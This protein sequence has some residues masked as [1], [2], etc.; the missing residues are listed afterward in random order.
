MCVVKDS[1]CLLEEKLQETI[2]TTRAVRRDGDVGTQAGE[3]RGSG[4]GGGGEAHTQAALG[5]WNRSFP[6]RRQ[7][8]RV[9]FLLDICVV[10]PITPRVADI[11]RSSGEQGQMEEKCRGDFG[12]VELGT[13]ELYQ[14]LN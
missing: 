1:G 11:K 10:G 13:R 5:L 4:G 9:W 12:H 3:K 8:T 2:E 7:G 14:M 6:K